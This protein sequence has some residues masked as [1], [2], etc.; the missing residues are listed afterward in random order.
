MRK[1]AQGRGFATES[2]N[3]LLRFAFGALGMRRVGLTHAE[4]NER[5]RRV[6]EKLG[7]RA[8][9]VQRG[10]SLLPGGRIA[11]KRVY[12]RFDTLGLPPLDVQWGPQ[13]V[14]HRPPDAHLAAHLRFLEERLLDPAFRNNPMAY[15][16]V[17]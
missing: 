6:A 13:Q 1:S 15:T 2:T 17:P 10:A 5:S 12:A 7:F 11:D 4:G 14:V 16:L 3:A 9:G 8:E